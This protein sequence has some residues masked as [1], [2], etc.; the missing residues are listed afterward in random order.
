MT[1][2]ELKGTLIIVGVFILMGIILVFT[3]SKPNTSNTW[4]NNPLVN[5]MPNRM[6]K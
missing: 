3:M 2:K 4:D 6:K 1:S 5:E